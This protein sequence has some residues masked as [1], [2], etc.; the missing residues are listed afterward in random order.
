MS[1]I[2]FGDCFEEMKKLKDKSIKLVLLDLPYGQ[3]ACGWDVCI[4]LKK[5]WDELIEYAII[6]VNIYFFVLLNL[7]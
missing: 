6:N 3:T 1:E 2:Y 5:M 7:E 4:D